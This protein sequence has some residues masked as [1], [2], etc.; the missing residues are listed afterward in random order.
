M[1]SG[2]CRKAY[3]ASMAIPDSGGQLHAVYHTP[4]PA[5]G[6]PLNIIDPATGSPGGGQ[7]EVS[8]SVTGPTGPEGPQGVQGIQGIQGVQ[9]I[10][11][12][13]GPPGSAPFTNTLILPA[14][15]FGSNNAGADD[16]SFIGTD[17][18]TGTVLQATYGF[19]FDPAGHPS[20]AIVYVNYWL[21]PPSVDG[22]GEYDVALYLPD[23]SFLTSATQNP[24]GP[25]WT[26][27]HLNNPPNFSFLVSD[28]P[29]GLAAGYCL[30]TH[31]C[32][33][34]TAFHGTGQIT[35]TIT[36]TNEPGNTAP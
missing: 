7:V 2:Q 24:A 31:R 32:T 6:T 23:G 11:G 27:P 36:T 10:Q 15:S 4:P 1:L 33:T 26:P 3:A 34:P 5:H 9:G 20:D 18:A 8:W 12:P 30:F 29:E 17:F 13:V 35:V 14:N 25:Y 28:F 16:G 22:Y 19:W 21:L